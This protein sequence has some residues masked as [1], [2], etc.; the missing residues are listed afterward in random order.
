MIP[1]AAPVLNG[2]E[3]EYVANVLKS[4][5][6]SHGPYVQKF[7]RAFAD[8]CGA[9]HAVATSSGTTALHLALLAL[10]VQPGDEVIVP[11]L[12]F[13]ATAAA[14]RYCG[15]VPIIADVEPLTWCLDA[16]AVGP[17]VTD[18][19]VGIIPVHLYGHPC[20][21]RTLQHV[22]NHFDLW[23]LED[24]AEAHGARCYGKKVGSIGDAAAFS[25]YGN[26]IL[27]MGE[28]GAVTTNDERLAVRMRHLGGHCQTA[29]GRYEHD[30]VG[31]NYRLTDLQAAVGLAQVERVG[32]HL[33]ARH[34]VAGWY[35][36]H[37]PLGLLELPHC[38]EYATR[39]PWV[40]PILLPEGAP[41]PAEVATLMQTWGVETRPIFTPLHRQTPY[42]SARPRPEA[43]RI[44]SRGLLLP[45]HEDM[46][47]E[48]VATV[49]AAL[50]C[51]LSVRRVYA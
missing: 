23:L 3:S 1:M 46:T 2:A 36:V 31:F 42:F 8:Y 11:A 51:A 19:T 15:A 40:M 21:M 30:G 27:T 28:G 9:S 4:T 20:D 5:R 7:E 24:A 6:L 17:L 12:T 22:A 48:D 47:E 43:E 37:L 45:L 10:G 50:D 41:S 25:F 38:A 35:G 33:L 18:R 34:A 44:A 14:V 26:K 49:A 29:P 39:A 16:S 32:A 13:A